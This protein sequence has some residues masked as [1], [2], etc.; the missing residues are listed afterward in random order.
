MRI[1]VSGGSGFIGSFVCERL[2]RSGHQVVTLTRRTDPPPGAIRWQPE[3]GGL[4][5]VAVEGFDGVVHLAGEN[6]GAGRWTAARRQRI[7]GSRRH[8]TRLLAATLAKATHRPAVLV[9]AS[10]VN[11]YGDRGDEVL[12]EDS[13]TGAGFLAEVCRQWEAATEPAS[14]ADIR[15]CRLRTGMV[16]A[17][18]GGAL[19]RL[20]L[21]FRLG[22]GG[23]LGSGKQWMSWI[24]R[25]DLAAVIERTLADPS[26]AGPV[27]A[28]SPG[29]VTNRE[30]STV[31]GRVLGRPAILPAPAAALR[32]A[33]GAMADELLLASQRVAPARLTA[34]G[35]TFVDDSLEPALRRLLGRP[36]PAA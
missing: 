22:L 2:R 6:I 32:L 9:S 35:F 25:D 17:A 11:F 21:P 23:R 1:L 8:G 27:N 31:V 26:L 16:L 20:L 19:A 7:L 33:L 13:P 18:D 10:G 28:V 24:T 36:A 30:F 29:S 4:D 5:P 34:T 15:V 12:T 14:D 3:D